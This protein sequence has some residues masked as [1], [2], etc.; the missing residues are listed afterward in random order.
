ML[1]RHQRPH[2]GGTVRRGPDFQRFDLRDQPLDQRLGDL[3]G[4]GNRHRDRHAAF[5]GRAVGRAHQC[6]DRHVEVGIGHD[7]HVVLRPTE[8]LHPLSV[9]GARLVDVPGDRSRTDEADRL[10]VGM[11][12]E[13]VD[14]LLAALDDIED[15]LRQ[16]GLGQPFRDQQ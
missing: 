13:C 3:V 4:H 12:K 5:A 7:H 14:R 6:I 9:G 11:F 16:P 10:D 2:I 8:C 15:A 1:R